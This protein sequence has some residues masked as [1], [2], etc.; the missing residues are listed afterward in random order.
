MKIEACL[1]CK[2]SARP[3]VGPRGDAR[4]AG[5]LVA[6]EYPQKR[7]VAKGYLFA[8]NDGDILFDTLRRYVDRSN[9]FILPLVCCQ[10]P[11]RKFPDNTVAQK[12]WKLFGADS[13]AQ[14]TGKNVVCAGYW[15]V[16]M[17][18]G[19]EL[20]EVHGKV[21]DAGGRRFAC[22]EHPQYYVK[23]HVK[24]EQVDG[25][26]RPAAGTME[27]AEKMFR[28]IEGATIAA[29]FND[30]ADIRMDDK[31]EIPYTRVT[32]IDEMVNRIEEHRGRI[33]FHDYETMSTV[34]KETANGRTA[35]D[36]F[37]G[38]EYVKPMCTGFTFFN[39]ISEI[40]YREGQHSVSYDRNKVCVLTVPLEERVARA[41][42]QCK[43]MAFNANYDTGVT[44]VNTGVRHDIYADP[45]D[46]AYVVNQSRK[47]Y[48]LASL[49]F[50]HVSELASWAGSIKAGGK[51]TK[52]E[53]YATMFRPELWAY[54]AGDC[55][56][57]MILFWKCLEKIQQAKQDFLFWNIM[58]GTRT[59]LRDMEARGVKVN[60]EVL[61]QVQE[62]FGIKLVRTVDELKQQPEVQWLEA[63]GTQWNPQS[64]PQILKIY[65]DFVG[66]G[67]ES[68]G[69]EII[70]AYMEKRDDEHRFSELLLDFRNYS[71]L[72]GTFVV[73][74]N[75]RQQ[76]GI[77]FASFKTNTTDTG[78]SSSGGSDT[79]G[80]G[81][82]NQINIQNIPRGSAM[83]RLYRARPGHYLAYADYSQIE[84]RVA[85]AY[86]RSKEIYNVC[87]SD[88]DFHGMMAAL[89]FKMEYEAVM[90]EDKAMSDAAKKGETV[91]DGTSTRTRSKAIT[92]G[93]LY[94]MTAEGL[95]KRLKLFLPNGELDLRAAEAY[96]VAYFAG[97]PS[98]KQFIDDTHAFVKLHYHVRTVFGRIRR[99]EWISGSALRKSVNTLVQATASDIFMLALQATAHELRRRRFVVNEITTGA[100]K[101]CLEVRSPGGV[102]VGTLQRRRV[103]KPLYGNVVHPWAEV[104]DAVTW[105]THVR[106]PK[107]EMR[108]IMEQAMV[109]DVRNTFRPVDEFLGEIP[110]HIDFKA[111]DVWV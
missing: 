49:A 16:R 19:R 22:I 72:N 3:H 108:A 23:R 25:R 84:V 17:L 37:Y 6:T 110:L 67:L 34:P 79:V 60:Q 28:Q 85:G 50:E 64:A 1:K 88:A 46:A 69:K 18:T 77:V 24:W 92:F 102:E 36:W 73:G 75:K 32:S 10:P 103:A 9:C 95:A 59:I 96:I 76:D 70:K 14:Y 54:C 68:T 11:D 51:K 86:A 8:G 12:C 21:I 82:T 47:R 7:D 56:I 57:S 99:F 87:V 90:A 61:P 89:A 80:L 55:V 26:W 105:E 39:D 38:A 91:G 48:N 27:M 98:V 29:L 94:G 81:K 52:G 41:M 74:M 5:L 33:L 53:N 78:R 30:Y 93:L 107:E 111:V 101:G 100:A 83:R 20:K 71:K 63:Q 97:M 40:G 44:L 66:A 42:Q 2:Y 45:I 106:F 15:A 104:H 35:L 13:Y 62:D 31:P 43:I 109:H 65:N 58:C 4:N